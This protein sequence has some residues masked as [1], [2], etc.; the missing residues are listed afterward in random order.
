MLDE[1]P[2][3]LPTLCL[4]VTTSCFLQS[5]VSFENADSFRNEKSERVIESFTLWIL[6]KIAEEWATGHGPDMH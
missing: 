5:V 2:Y 3:G 4:Q 1:S 6:S